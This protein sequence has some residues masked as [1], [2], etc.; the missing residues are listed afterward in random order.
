MLSKGEQT[1]SE[2]DAALA[3]LRRAAENER[4]GF[5]FYRE[6]V[7]R[8]AHPQGRE[9]FESL[10]ND[11]TRHLRLLL[12]EYQSLE[13]G[14]GWVDP[15]EAMERDVDVD[16]SQPLFQGAE[17]SSMAFP[18]DEAER[19]EWDELQTDL[20]VL[21]FGMETEEQFYSMYKSALSEAGPASLAAPAYEFLM[22]EENRHF[23]LL[24]EAHE[25]LDENGVW[26]D[27]W[28]RPIFEGG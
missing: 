1:M 13:R 7:A 20:A 17:L 23:M 14:E 6:A 18:W 11:E 27:D 4:Q 28:Q 9:M 2:M 25:Y 8:T 3:I 22:T 24:Q 10:G 26:W 19:Q 15:E 16:L 5:H 12:A 21:R